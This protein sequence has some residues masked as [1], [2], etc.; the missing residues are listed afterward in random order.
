MRNAGA[1]FLLFC[2]SLSLKPLLASKEFLE[3]KKY[4]EIP[5]G[6]FIETINDSDETGR[7]PLHHASR[8]GHL[9]AILNILKVGAN[10]DTL[11]Q[12]GNETAVYLAAESGHEIIVSALISH[13][14]NVNIPNIHGVTPLY[15]A[16]QSGHVRVVELL[17][18]AG[19]RLE[20][21]GGLTPLMVAA[22]RGNSDVVKLFVNTSDLDLNQK[23]RDGETALMLCTISRDALC[24]QYLL[25]KGANQELTDKRGYTALIHAA[26]RN[27]PEI[28]E[29]LISSGSDMEVKDRAGLTAIQHAQVRSNNRDSLTPELR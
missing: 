7:T 25:D 18:G 9:E 2:I 11:S 23:N 8:V 1:S 15:I 4:A 19:A 5:E 29:K 17:L 13:N 26:I 20:S 28:M 3:V 14:A 6:L 22:I 16:S 21:V 12:Y 27:C 10:I 24:L